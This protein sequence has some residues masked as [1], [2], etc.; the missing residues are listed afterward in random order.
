MSIGAF[1]DSVNSFKKLLDKLDVLKDYRKD[2]KGIYSQDFL[3][4]M[5]GNYYY[6]IYNVAI[7][8]YDYELLLNDDSFFQFSFRDESISMAFY[9]K[10]IDYMSF[11]DYI[12]DVFNDY[13]ISMSDEE[14]MD[15]ESN[16]LADGDYYS[17]YEQYLI[18]K[19]TLSNIVPIRFDFD[20]KYYNPV[21]HPLCHLHIGCS[22]DIRIAFDK[23]PTPHLFGLFTLKNYYPNN[24]F[25]VDEN[26][27][28]IINP[29]IDIPSKVTCVNVQEDKFVDENKIF[30]FT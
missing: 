7:K 18:E 30:Y 14:L 25:D 24:F 16:I 26:K 22:N 6:D 9:P 1:W 2:K 4:S 21:Y 3:N 28:K 23:H 27:V 20:N 13:V 17:D 10:P 15:F 12:Y 29:L 19:Q 11:K 8:N 5:Y